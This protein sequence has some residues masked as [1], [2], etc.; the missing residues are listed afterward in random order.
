MP[1]KNPLAKVENGT[2]FPTAATSPP[3][4]TAHEASAIRRPT[5]SAADLLPVRLPRFSRWTPWPQ[6]GADGRSS[7]K[8][9]LL[10]PRGCQGAID[11]HPL[12]FPEKC[13]DP[14]SSAR[15]AARSSFRWMACMMVS[16]APTVGSV[17]V[18]GV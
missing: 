1:L 2:V 17:Y 12:A 8:N 14:H 4:R 3:A 5:A 15:T 7:G 16:P 6:C 18:G 13:R 11:D 10:A 9:H